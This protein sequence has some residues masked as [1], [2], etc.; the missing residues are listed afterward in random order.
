MPKYDLCVIGGGPAGMIAAGRAAERGK[1]VVLIEKNPRLGDKFLLTGGGRCNLTHITKDNK[2][3]V[4]NFGKNGDFLLSALS[5]FSFNELIDFFNKKDLK[6]F[7]DKNKKVFPKTEKSKDVLNLLENYLKDNNVK[8]LINSEVKDF[9][10]NKKTIEKIILTSDKEIEASNF[11]IATGGKSY[12]G[13]GS[14]GD[15]YAFAK[16]MGHTIIKPIPALTPIETKEKWPRRIQGTALERAKV[17][18]NNKSILG[19]VVFTQFGASGPAILNLSG[20]IK[21]TDLVYLDLIPDKNQEQ[22]NLELIKLFDK[23]SGKKILNTLNIFVPEKMVAIV[24][25]IALIDKDKVCQAITKQ[26]RLKLIKTFK[27][28]KLTTIGLL[29]FEKAMITKGGVSLK[30]IDSK[31]M[32]SK[33]IDNLYFAGEVID[34]NG[35]SGGFNLQMCF[36]TGYVVAE[37]IL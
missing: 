1:K 37:A 11:L 19:E 27:K 7:I 16:K 5:V 34:L 18:V 2:E 20:D 22:L 3:F 25:E 36:T 15:G 24:L 8:V 13:T 32:K 33:I 30:E 6:T 31:Q 9:V 17:S 35:L 29:G 12:P 23:N 28:I 10:L 26:E 4:S 14:T 21:K